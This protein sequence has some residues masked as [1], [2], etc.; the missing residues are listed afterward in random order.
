MISSNIL[1]TLLT[2]IQVANKSLIQPIYLHLDFKNYN[3]VPIS[4][5]GMHTI[6][7]A[8]TTSTAN[9]ILSYVQQLMFLII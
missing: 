2:H 7:F 3:Y 1:T 6:I 4:Q 9:T 5:T 8:T